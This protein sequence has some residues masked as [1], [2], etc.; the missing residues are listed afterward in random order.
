MIVTFNSEIILIAF[1]ANNIYP[2]E[3]LP[4][5]RRW[6]PV[7]LTVPAQG[8]SRGWQ[9]GAQ[10]WHNYGDQ[11]ALFPIREAWEIYPSVTVTSSGDHLPVMPAW[12][13]V[14]RAVERELRR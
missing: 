3:F 6:L 14:L 1:S 4:I 11:A 2:L 12:A 5:R 8:F 9:I 10:Q 13:D 7:E